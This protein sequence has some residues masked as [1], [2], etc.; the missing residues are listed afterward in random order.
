MKKPK[1]Q[2]SQLVW[3]KPIG[4]LIGFIKEKSVLAEFGFS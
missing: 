2:Q 1:L 3:R 4:Y